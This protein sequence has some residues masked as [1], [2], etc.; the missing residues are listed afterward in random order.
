M[1]NNANK[2][3][4]HTRK[5][6][7]HYFSGHI[8]EF[9]ILIPGYRQSVGWLYGAYASTFYTPKEVHP[10]LTTSPHFQFNVGFNYGN[11]NSYIA[12]DL[13]QFTQTDVIDDPSGIWTN[14]ASLVQ[15]PSSSM[16]MNLIGSGGTTDNFYLAN[17]NGGSSTVFPNVVVNQGQ[18]Q[19]IRSIVA[20]FT[21]EQNS[22]AI[23]E[24]S[25]FNTSPN[26]GLSWSDLEAGVGGNLYFNSYGVL[27]MFPFTSFVEYSENL[28][29]C[30]AGGTGTLTLNVCNDINS[31]SYWETTT[32]DCDGISIPASVI[33]DPST[34]TLLDTCC[35]DCIHPES[36]VSP[37]IY[38]TQP[39][40]L[41]VQ[42]TNPT[43]PGGTN[44]Y[45]D[46]TI[47]DQGFNSS[48]IPL[49]LPTG[50]SNYTFV[51]EHQSGLAMSGNSAGV[52][53]G[54]GPTTGSA[55]H[56]S[57]TFGQNVL[58]TNNNGGLVQ[59]GSA[60]S[61]TY[62]ASSIT[63]YVPAATGTTN[64]S[65]LAAGNYTVYVFDSGGV[66]CLATATI[67]LSDPQPISGCTDTNA[68]NTNPLATVANNTTCHYCND[69]TGELVDGN[70]PANLV[71]GSGNISQS[72]GSPFTVFT[73]PTHTTATNTVVDI[74]GLSPTAVFQAYINDVV[75][76]S[77]AQNADYM[78][79]LYKWTTQTAAGS[80]AAS[81]I[82]GSAITNV[83]SNGWNIL[84]DT[85]TLGAGL[86][87]GYYSIK[88]W[89]S[90]PDAVVEIEDCYEII[91][92]IIPV[93]T[94]V[95]AGIATAQDGVIITD[96]N[97]YFHDPV[98][99]TISLN[100]C[101]THAVLMPHHDNDGCSLQFQGGIS[102]TRSTQFHEITLQY[103]DNGSWIDV[104]TNTFGT[105][106]SGGTSYPNTWFTGYIYNTNTFN[107]YGSG[108]YRLEW[109]SMIPNNT[110]CT[111][112]SSGVSITL[113]VWGC[114]DAAVDGQGN[115]ATNYNPLATCPDSC[116]WCIY[117][118]TDVTA[119]NYNSLATCDEGCMYDVYGCTDITATNYNPLAT[120]DDGSC[121]YDP[122]G[123][124]DAF[125]YNWGIDCA[126]NVVSSGSSPPICDDGCCLYC[127]DPAMGVTVSTVSATTTI[128]AS[129]TGFYCESNSDGCIELVVTSTTC[130]NGQWELITCTTF[131]GISQSTTNWLTPGNYDYDTAISF[132]NLPA[133]TYTFTLVDCNGCTLIVD[134]LINSTGN[135]CGCTDPLAINYNG[136]ASYD[137]GTYPALT[138][139]CVPPGID[140]V[141]R[142]FEVCIAENGFDYYNKL[143]TGQSDDCSIM[144]VWKLILMA[145]LL[146]KKG[147]D[148]IYNC[149]DAN[150]PS[151]AQV[152]K[153]CEDI[154]ITG[155]PSTGLNDSA[156]TGT[157]VGTTSDVTMFTTGSLTPGDVI[158]HHVSGNIWTFYGP[159]QNGS[160]V[161]VSVAGLDP[162]NASGN[163]SGYWNWCNNS[164]RYISNENNINYLDNFITFVNK[165]CRDCG[166]DPKGLVGSGSNLN[167]PIIQ[168]G[169]DGIEG[170][171]I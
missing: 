31:L 126:G 67:Y 114:M 57:F 159:G 26:P 155:G 137:D 25:A 112:Y 15:I 156:V 3:Y 39:F 171:E 81:S 123:C 49:G 84:L 4:A 139:P 76:G 99:C 88:I 63:G 89:I 111:I 107:T 72:S 23:F 37:T 135:V 121:L 91:D 115:Q 54:S 16:H 24:F 106:S 165:F 48:G 154:W 2:A 117:G 170:L 105:Q 36:A 40:T 109:T 73:S 98:L 136:A 62:V 102:C 90:D 152:Y 169:I 104:V 151:P 116:A 64:T 52:N 71:G 86:T 167:I 141:I 146:K 18:R 60:G 21:P 78:V 168:Q 65:G 32:V 149:Q 120:I 153:S 101:C 94:C 164:M 118:C 83:Q 13:Y 68:L 77:G 148:C 132:C 93:P 127:E 30:E 29:S 100:E 140:Q 74:S 128:V 143:I 56:N 69:V 133:A 8:E 125:A 129:G 147:L 95:D 14:G 103:Y 166:N 113:G 142:R 108:I 34:A 82:I 59:T 131:C 7:V 6:N 157:G 38:S 124:T 87:Y 27:G 44:G 17:A 130:L 33:T 11:T 50:V 43:T 41:N 42:G 51:L 10:C 97:L 138:A 9:E 92:F 1:Q 47:L 12:T 96:P 79:S 122:C 134:V 61:S 75:D 22:D 163:L 158:K 55:T 28:P 160:P 162:E 70:N 5:Y 144:N 85:N 20:L 45:I 80:F 145:Y 46:A 53:I 110:L 66:V 161:P 58:A 35:P 19:K 119:T 150:T